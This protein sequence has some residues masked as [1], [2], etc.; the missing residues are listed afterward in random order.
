[1]NPIYSR[2]ISE[3]SKIDCTIL[4]NMASH[5]VEEFFE[6]LYSKE[7]VE[8]IIYYS[9]E[10]AKQKNNH[11]FSLSSNELKVFIG[12]LLLSGYHKEP[13]EDM[14]L[15]VLPDADLPI[16]YN[17]MTQARFRE[18]KRYLHLRD[19]SD[20]D[21]KDKFAK[22]RPYLIELQ[23]NY[24]RFGIFASCLS[25]DEMMIKYYG[26]HSAKMFMRGKVLVPV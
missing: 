25:L 20:L 19:N 26:M 9:I 14:Y 8:K 1:M 23:T 6:L 15:E 16:I 4:D 12:I 7:L 2:E 3:T 11:E 21:R 13:Q 10:Y 18:I 22:V 24:I 17:A 5:T